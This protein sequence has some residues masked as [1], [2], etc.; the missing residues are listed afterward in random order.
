[1][2]TFH[3]G[4]FTRADRAHG[5]CQQRVI[6]VLKAQ[7][8]GRL[9]SALGVRTRTRR[10]ARQRRPLIAGMKAAGAKIKRQFT[11]MNG[12]AATV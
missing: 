11:V 7:P 10:E 2:P 3:R 5:A 6:V 8:T 4:P 9:R 12:F 1:M